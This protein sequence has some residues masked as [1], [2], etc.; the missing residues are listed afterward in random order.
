MGML[1][2]Y[3]MI[4]RAKLE[5]QKLNEANFY[6]YYLHVNVN[7]RVYT[8]INVV[9]F[10]IF[11]I[12]LYLQVCLLLFFIVITGYCNPQTKSITI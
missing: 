8:W 10:K 12:Y 7:N 3:K 4:V 6:L 9:Y 2:V 5:I 11:F 1:N